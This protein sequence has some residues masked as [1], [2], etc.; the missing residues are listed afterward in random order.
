M[1]RKGEL[2]YSYGPNN[3]T[4]Y[5]VWKIDHNTVCCVSLE[6]HS[7]WHGYQVPERL[8][9]D[10]SKIKYKCFHARDALEAED[11]KSEYNSHLENICDEDYNFFDKF[12]NYLNK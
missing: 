2:I 3:F 8:C 12:I 10:K 11:T 5:I 7:V 9:I 6:A 4:P 1:V